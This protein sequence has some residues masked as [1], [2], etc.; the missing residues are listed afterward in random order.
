[1]VGISD[2]STDGTKVAAGTDAQRPQ[3]P[4][5]GMIRHNTEASALETYDGTQWVVVSQ[6][7][8]G[9]ILTG[10]TEEQ[11]APSAQYLI[12]NSA[13]TTN[14]FYWI[15]DESGQNPA[16]QVYCDIQGT[17]AGTGY[18]RIDSTWASYYGGAAC[19]SGTGQVDANGTLTI[20]V[21]SG[22]GGSGAHGGCGVSVY[23]PYY[24]RYMNLTNRSFTPNGNWGGVPF[25]NPSWQVNNTGE[26]NDQ[27]Y[28]PI[29]SGGTY[30]GWGPSSGGPSEFS[31]NSPP[32]G[33]RDFGEYANRIMHFGGGGY[34]GGF[35][36]PCS[37]KFWF[38]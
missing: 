18:M 4:Q 14:G 36:R 32:S 15:E 27:I 19:N 1:M 37:A 38:K 24:A 8:D 31:Q 7:P 33:E 29:S 16:R 30:P 12:D 34:S 35:G 11:A 28:S 21:N 22:G 26:G 3:S 10:A 2:Q 9:R 6:Q 17:E 20:S 23:T 13:Q 5:A 25:P